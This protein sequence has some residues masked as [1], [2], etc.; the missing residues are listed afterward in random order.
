MMQNVKCCTIQSRCFCNAVVPSIWKQLLYTLLI[1]MVSLLEG[2]TAALTTSHISY[3]HCQQ[4]RCS[5]AMSSYHHGSETTY[6][7]VKY[8]RLK[9]TAKA[10]YFTV[11]KS[12]EALS[13]QIVIQQDITIKAPHLYIASIYMVS[14]IYDSIPPIIQM[15]YLPVTVTHC[16][17][18]ILTSP[19]NSV[20]ISYFL[21]V[22]TD[23]KDP[24]AVVV[25]AMGEFFNFFE[26]FDFCI[27]FVLFYAICS[28]QYLL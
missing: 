19:I 7:I 16:I 15:T 17:R 1:Q 24:E 3:L 8:H 13:L 6:H 18:N 14:I 2:H 4:E 11:Q 12:A 23:S 9:T 26:M 28:F 21:L 22:F 10:P 25:C 27:V 5:G 20:S